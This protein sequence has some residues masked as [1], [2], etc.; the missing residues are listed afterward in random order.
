MT[1]APPT[2]IECLTAGMSAE[3]AAEARGVSV[4]AAYNWARK[5]AVRW[6]EQRGTY[7]NIT[8]RVRASSIARAKAIE[9]RR[10]AGETLTS[11]GKSA[12]ITKQAVHQRIRKN[13]LGSVADVLSLLTPAAQLWLN[14]QVPAGGTVA[15]IIAA[16]VTDAYAEEM[17]HD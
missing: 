8:A 2:W 1:D 11:I 6:P 16:I 17:G 5:I 12:G 13:N 4:Y 9:E 14:K 7:E 10:R 3:Q 15:D